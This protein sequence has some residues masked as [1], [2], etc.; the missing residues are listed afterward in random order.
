RRS[1]ERDILLPALASARHDVQRPAACGSADRA[2]KVA[3][4]HRLRLLRRKRRCCYRVRG[5]RLGLWRR[6]GGPAHHAKHVRH[7][8]CVPAPPGMWADD[9]RLR[10]V[11]LV[12]LCHRGRG[13]RRVQRACPERVSGALHAGRRRDAVPRLHQGHAAQDRPRRAPY[14]GRV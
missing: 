10:L 4:L 12:C 1:A 11:L 2:R 8:H 9:Q 13:P 6:R 14:M 7:Q 3:L 5:W